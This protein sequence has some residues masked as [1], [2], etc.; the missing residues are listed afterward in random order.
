MGRRLSKGKACI[1]CIFLVITAAL[2]WAICIQV[3][4]T[5]QYSIW[6]SLAV[7]SQLNQD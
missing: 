5:V 4:N 1:L 3:A 2:M 7:T 6:N